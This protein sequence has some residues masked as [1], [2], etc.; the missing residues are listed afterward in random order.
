[1][2]RLDQKVAL[3]SGAAR[4]IGAATAKLMALAGAK[5]IIGDVLDEL[6]Q[7]TIRAIEATGGNAEYAHLDV[8][9]EEQWTAAVDLATR[10]Y[11]KLDILV[12]YAGVFV[13]NVRVDISP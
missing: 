2:S 7:Q 4:G 12:N 8:T 5:V 11:G 1:M 3:I 9:K 13:V 6:G 10:R